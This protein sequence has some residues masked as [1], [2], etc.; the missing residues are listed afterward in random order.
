MK[1]SAAIRC[2][3]Q[4]VVRRTVTASLLLLSPVTGFAENISHTYDALNRLIRT[5]YG[6][7]T[8]IEYTYDAAGN[9]LSRTAATNPAPT[10]SMNVPPIANAGPD[11]TVS[12]GAITYLNGGG[13]SDP[14]HGPSPLSY[15]WSQTAGVPVNLPGAATVSPSFTPN[16][17]GAYAFQLVLSDGQALS[18]PDFVSVTAVGAEAQQ[19][20]PF[21]LLEPNGGESYHAGKKMLVRWTAV[22]FISKQKLQLKYSKNG[23][24]KWKLLKTVKNTGTTLW[25]PTRSQSSEQARLMICVPKTKKT[26]LVCDSSDGTFHIRR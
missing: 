10:P 5:D 7:G 1:P 11:M 12:A 2:R 24:T 19:P 4:S 14:D 25:K 23:Q 17:P 13:S 18:S 15:A 22:N 9:R 8:I 26:P 20:L 16:Q 3:G 6:N 21:Q